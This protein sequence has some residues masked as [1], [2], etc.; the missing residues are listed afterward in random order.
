MSSIEQGMRDG[1]RQGGY[2][3]RKEQGKL[4][5]ANEW[6]ELGFEKR[7]FEE[8]GVEKLGLQEKAERIDSLEQRLA[9]DRGPERERRQRPGR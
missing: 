6:Q 4:V 2:R 9:C 7:G 8:L 5:E 1:Q 3:Q